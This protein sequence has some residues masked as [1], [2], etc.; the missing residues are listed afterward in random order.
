[1]DLHLQGH[2][3]LLVLN[4]ESGGSLDPLQFP[5]AGCVSRGTQ[6]SS[7]DLPVGGDQPQ[8]P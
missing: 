6:W 7:H 1:M 8:D 3:V 5:E 2:C 4:H